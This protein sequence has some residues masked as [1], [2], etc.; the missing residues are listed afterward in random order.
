MSDLFRNHMLSQPTEAERDQ[1]R[2]RLI[3]DQDLFDQFRDQENDWIDA[4]AAGKLP[5]QD[6]ALL[7]QHLASTG[8]LRRLPTAKA[9]QKPKAPSVFPYAFAIAAAVVLCFLATLQLR[10]KPQI[11]LNLPPSVTVPLYPGTLRD[12]APVPSVPLSA[13]FTTIVHLFYQDTAPTGTCVITIR[14]QSGLDLSIAREPCGAA[15]HSHTIS[16]SIPAGRYTLFLTTS[17]NELIHTYT[18]D[19][20]LPPP[21]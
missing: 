2:E 19:I 7:H 18:F 13:D 16:P 5:P 17:N 6:A 21:K 8:Q 10:P 11:A 4:F 14:S 20:T 9:L 3:A 15:S 1:L 12:G